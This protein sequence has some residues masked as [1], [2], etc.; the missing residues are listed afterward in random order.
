M[1]LR[2]A[3]SSKPSKLKI[4]SKKITE[5]LGD[6]AEYLLGHK[7]KTISEGA[8]AFTGARFCRSDLDQQ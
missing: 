8:I 6:K 3:L 4:M 7:S 2:P 5:L 1:V